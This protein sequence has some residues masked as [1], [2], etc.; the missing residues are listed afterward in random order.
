MKIKLALPSEDKLNISDSLFKT[1][2]FKITTF[3]TATIIHEEYRETYTII[4]VNAETEKNYKKI[5]EI[6]ADCD[7]IIFR[8]I[9]E[10]FANYLKS[11][12]KQ[13]IITP[14]KII[15]NAV[16]KYVIEYNQ[17]ESNTCCC[18]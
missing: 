14:E 13:V 12:E 10:K 5:Y 1:Y 6:I 15:T 11:R 16:L 7:V 17:R 4:D 8:T 3:D 18:P 9:S 2:F